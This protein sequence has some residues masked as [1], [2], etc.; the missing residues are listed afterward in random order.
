MNPEKAPKWIIVS[1]YTNL[2][3]IDY[4]CCHVEVLDYEWKQLISIAMNERV[5]PKS[6]C[7][8]TDNCTWP[9]KISWPDQ[10]LFDKVRMSQGKGPLEVKGQT[11][12]FKPGVPKSPHA[13]GF[14][15]ELAFL[16]NKQSTTICG[17]KP[18]KSMI[19]KCIKVHVQIIW[20]VVVEKFLLGR[21]ALNIMNILLVVALMGIGRCNILFL[22]NADKHIA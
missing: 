19:L 21:Q 7:F 1:P 22:P 11:W 5:V 3:I 18:E 15:R 4:H 12:Y 2:P 8:E 9:M 6:W 17:A 20:V 16:M 14:K 13:N 10:I